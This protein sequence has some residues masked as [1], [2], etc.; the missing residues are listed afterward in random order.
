MT[1][2]KA[3]IGLLGLA[4]VFGASGNA[5]ATLIG[6]LVNFQCT[7]CGPPTLDSFVVLDG[8]PELSLFGQFQVDVEEDYLQI[9]WIFTASNITPDLN[10]LWTSLNAGSPILGAS[11]D[12]SSTW[13]TSPLASISFTADSV[14]LT[15]NNDNDVTTGDF[16]RINLD[17]GPAVPEPGTIALVGFGL[18]GLAARRG[19]RA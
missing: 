17:L 18:A 15:N 11:I 1:K 16:V 12:P 3:A 2:H 4:F 8:L 14:S 13:G 6:D 7:N 10:F 9:N 19:K 5:N